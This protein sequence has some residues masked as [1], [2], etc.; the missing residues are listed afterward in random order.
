MNQLTLE[1]EVSLLRSAVIG[2]IG[3]DKEGEYR[4]E[5]V[6]ETFAALA[7]KPE[8]VF[9]S[10]EEFLARLETKKKTEKVKRA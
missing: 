3:R 5:F 4:P 8:F 2:L 9:S 10:P 1:Q 6:E 7:E